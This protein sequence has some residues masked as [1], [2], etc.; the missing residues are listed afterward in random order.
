MLDRR[1]RDKA[2]DSLRSYLRQRTNLTELELLKLWKGLFFC[3]WMSDKPRYQQQL[4]RE[5]AELID[6]LPIPNLI[7]FLEAFWT[8]MAKE[9]TG[10][11]V[12]R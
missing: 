9:W 11:D 5:L 4:A 2:L 1:I 12:L 6:V 3:M 8:T 7:P 10:I